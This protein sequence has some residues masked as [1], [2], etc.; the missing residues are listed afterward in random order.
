GTAVPYLSHLWSVAA[1]VLEHGGDDV[2]VAAALL[3]DVAEDH[4]GVG[5]L[6]DVRARFGD[7][8]AALVAA[9]SDSLADTDAGEAK[10]PWRTRK[11]E[12][13]E[14]LAGADRRVALV[15]ACD[16]LHNARCVLADLRAVGPA[17]WARFNAP[18]PADQLWL[19]DAL[20]A[21]L[22]APRVPAPLAGELRRTVAA[23]R[24]EVESGA[25][26]SGSGSGSGGS[27]A[28]SGA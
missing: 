23:I 5:R 22:R 12:Y 27:G 16:K 17:V 4:G 11:A 7:D 20:C 10:A 21:A 2:Q 24:A 9:L 6:A 19:Y 25:A 1:L 14:H 3:H 8:V 15:S 13:V 18:D 26:G 28:G